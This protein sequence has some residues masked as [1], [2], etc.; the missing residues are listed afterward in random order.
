MGIYINGLKMPKT[1]SECFFC[2]TIEEVYVGD[3]LYKKIGK[4]SLADGVEDP[5][6]DVHWQIKNKEEW[7]PL[8]E[9]ES[10]SKDIEDSPC[11]FWVFCGSDRWNDV[12]ACSACGKMHT[13]DSN[14]CP[15]CGIRMNGGQKLNNK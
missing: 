11:G 1:C 5:W 6:R 4:C 15:N 7:C 12:Y 2:C 9:V 3:G 8:K 13:D 14:Y 10:F